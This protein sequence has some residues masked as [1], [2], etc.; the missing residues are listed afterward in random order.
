MQQSAIVRIVKIVAAVAASV[1]VAISRQHL[2]R[3]STKT[4]MITKQRQ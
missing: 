2:Q 3:K 4:I 1:V